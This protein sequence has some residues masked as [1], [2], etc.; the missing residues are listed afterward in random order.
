MQKVCGN[1]FEVWIMK[2]KMLKQATA[3]LCDESLFFPIHALSNKTRKRLS[4]WLSM[5]FRAVSVLLTTEKVFRFAP[6][7]LS[8]VNLRMQYLWQGSYFFKL[9]MASVFIFIFYIY[10]MLFMTF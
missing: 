8:Q 2:N 10:K 6:W 3:Q 1:Y 5:K 9:M 4:F 7:F